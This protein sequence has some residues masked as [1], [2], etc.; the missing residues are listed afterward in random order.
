MRDDTVV[1][2]ISVKDEDFTRL[3]VVVSLSLLLDEAHRRG[4]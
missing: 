1:G 2:Y 4:H 3:K